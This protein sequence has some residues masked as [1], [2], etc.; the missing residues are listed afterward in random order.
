MEL[1]G[2]RWH[3]LPQQRHPLP[4]PADALH[5]ASASLGIA[6]GWPVVKQLPHCAAPS[7]GGFGRASTDPLPPLSASLL[8]RRAIVSF[9]KSCTT[10]LEDGW[11]VTKGATRWLAAIMT[12]HVGGE[13][14]EFVL[15]LP[16]DAVARL[17]HLVPD[18]RKVAEGFRNHEP[19]L[20]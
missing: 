19:R 12:T 9:A 11:R 16:N 15:P 6:A 18:P 13:C 2:A 14:L 20:A 4:A 10:F 7:S 1:G 17:G 5:L 3:T 8:Y